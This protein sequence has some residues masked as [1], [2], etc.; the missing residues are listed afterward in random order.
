MTPPLRIAFLCTGVEIFN[1]G[2]ESFFREAYDGLRGPLASMGIEARLFKGGGRSIPERGETRVWCLPR[3]G[4]LASLVGKPVRRR[5]YVVEQLTFLPG[6][7][8][9]VRRL[10]PDVIF[11][12]DFDIAR[13]LYRWRRHIGVPYRLLYSNGAPMHPP[14]GDT[15]FV[16]QV[17]PLY[18]EEAIAA[19]EPGGIQTHVPYGMTV[20]T[21]D[22]DASTEGQL[23]ARRRLDLPT[24][25]KILLSVGAINDYHKRMDY[26]IR[27]CARIKNATGTNPPFLVLLGSIEPETARMV[28]LADEL[29]GTQ[30]Y[31]VRSVP[32][33]QVSDYYRA[34]DVF[35]LSSLKEGFG[36][37][38]LE[39]LV[40]GLPTIGHDHPVIRYVLGEVGR[41]ADLATLGTLAGV[42]VEELGR[43]RDPALMARRRASVRDRF[44]WDRIAPAYAAMFRQAA[45]TSI[46]AWK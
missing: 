3:T 37:V 17:A 10:R 11:Y 24:D 34:A 22:P 13:R 14:F 44:A 5:P 2:I 36:R 31:V 6:M 18:Y 1:R 38:Y 8:R 26:T 27:E 4:R 28:A 40:H 16:Q 15:D 41:I 35:V 9:H 20:P 25:R 23:A 46:P 42:L 39:S 12:S 30:N 33:A 7:I 43:P 19:G 21:G 45:A 29:L 32:Y